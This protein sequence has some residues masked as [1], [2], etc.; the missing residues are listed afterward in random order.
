[1]AI[2]A[3]PVIEPK[4]T[5]VT[6][7]DADI[8]SPKQGDPVYYGKPIL[9][10]QRAVVASAGHEVYVDWVFR[11]EYGN[12]VDIT[13]LDPCDADSDS[14][15]SSSSEMSMS[16]S[17]SSSEATT[18]R[19]EAEGCSQVV[20]RFREILDFS[21]TTPTYE[22]CGEVTNA[23]CGEVR[24]FIDNKNLCPGVYW[25]EIAVLDA[26]DCPVLSNVFRLVIE[27]SLW[28]MLVPDRPLDHIRFDDAEMALAIVR[29]LEYWNEQPPN[30]ARATTSNFPHRFHWMDAIAANLFWMVEEQFRANNLSYSAAGVQVNDQDKEQ[31]YAR[32][33]ERRWANWVKFVRHKK[34][35]LN[36]NQCWGAVGSS[37]AY[38]GLYGGKTRF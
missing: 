37:Y 34:A 6:V 16:S 36:Y 32:A 22:C 28:A 19:C 13:N 10:R 27:R 20:M 18:D 24:V 8:Q 15:S 4:T 17:S 29:P 23:G 11:D 38:V 12:P 7:S 30:I 5:T 33:A 31:N 9:A 3:T 25:A 26:N 1:M 14:S 21:G 35:E 2:E